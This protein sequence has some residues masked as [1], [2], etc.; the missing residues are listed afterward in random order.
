MQYNPDPFVE[1]KKPDNIFL[2]RIECWKHTQLIADKL[3]DPPESIKYQYDSDFFMHK[4]YNTRIKV[5]NI[6]SIDC[7]INLHKRGFNPVVLNLADDRVAGGV[8]SLGSG[9]QEESLYR[10]TNL[11]KTL[12]T[13]HRLYPIE[14]GEAILS[15]N[16][17]VLKTSERDGWQ[18]R[19]K[20]I[21]LDFIACPGIYMPTLDYPDEK[22]GR[23]R[24]RLQPHDVEKL[25]I[26]I[27]TILQL[28]YHNRNDSV[29]LGAIGCGAFKNPSVHVAEIFKEVLAEY[30]GVFRR[31]HFAILKNIDDMYIM[32]SALN[33]SGNRKDNYEIFREV[34]TK[35]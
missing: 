19:D 4:Q 24:A 15:K 16:V 17:M 8:V 18:P 14:D 32:K 11:H 34:F 28:A 25:R 5:E 27:R 22:S 20:P 6:D 10:R 3:P 26:K 35:G 33:S 30:H 31:I 7:G 21:W 13:E 12:K 1:Y 2:K 23:E 9:A 29:V